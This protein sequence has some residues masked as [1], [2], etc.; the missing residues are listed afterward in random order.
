MRN[1][2][3][4]LTE[5]IIKD[6]KMNSDSIIEHL[7]E[8]L[9]EC[10]CGEMEKEYKILYEE[11]YGKKLTKE[12]AEEWVHSMDSPDTGDGQK[13]SLES[14]SEYGNK[15]NMDWTRHSKIDFYC[16]M[17]MMYSDYYRTA[18][19][20]NMLSDTMFFAHLSKDWLCDSDAPDDKLYKYYFE[21]IM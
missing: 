20:M 2:L 10:E 6:G 5:V 4:K 1:K 14:T 17:N 7:T 3:K 12:I 21:V 18:K 11:S 16:V 13:W 8:A 15:V 9:S 19:A